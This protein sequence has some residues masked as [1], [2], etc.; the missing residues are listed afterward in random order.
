MGCSH[1]KTLLLPFSPPCSFPSLS[2]PGTDLAE[3]DFYTGPQVSSS[4]SVPDRPWLQPRLP[5]VARYPPRTTQSLL[6]AG[7]SVMNG[8]GRR[9]ARSF[10]LQLLSRKGAEMHSGFTLRSR[11]LLRRKQ[12]FLG[13]AF[14][15]A[16]SLLRVL[17]GLLVALGMSSLHV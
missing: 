12:C 11:S 16:G 10:P 1:H 6:T 14:V 5:G 2:A 17:T 7:V 3:P 4:K 15:V 8:V 9:G 13:L